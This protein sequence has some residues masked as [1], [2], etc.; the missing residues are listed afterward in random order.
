MNENREYK[1]DV[2]LDAEK[3]C[4]WNNSV[5]FYFML[6]MVLFYWL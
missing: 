2:A 5:P 4:F 6:C 1:S 3:M